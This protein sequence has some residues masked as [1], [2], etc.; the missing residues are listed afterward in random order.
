MFPLFP[1]L[2]PIVF[3]A[4]WIGSSLFCL[5]QACYL[6][7]PRCCH[8]WASSHGGCFCLFKATCFLVLQPCFPEWPEDY[9]TV[10]QTPNPAD[11]RSGNMTVVC[12][13]QQSMIWVVTWLL[14]DW[15]RLGGI[16]HI[17]FLDPFP[18]ELNLVEKLIRPQ[19]SS[20]VWS[21][22]PHFCGCDKI[23][24]QKRT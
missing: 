20:F 22:L 13:P 10:P 4:G 9:S 6:K 1:S 19:L 5:P 17:R 18:F 21:V 2:S 14:F 23:S 7:L 12:C 24:W 11:G 16:K 8:E 15:D 3:S